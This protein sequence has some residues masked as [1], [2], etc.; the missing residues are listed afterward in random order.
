VLVT[1]FVG[2]AAGGAQPGLQCRL[3]PWR[4]QTPPG[5]QPGTEFTLLEDLRTGRSCVLPTSTLYGCRT[6]AL[7]ALAARTLVAPGVVTGA[8]LGTSA[9]AQLSL[10]LMARY[11][12]GLSH[13]AVCPTGDELDRPVAARVIDQL[14]LAGV[15][16]S[17]STAV[18]EAMFGA[19]LIVATITRTRW[20][21]TGQLPQGTVLINTSGEDPPSN[22]INAV[23]QVYVDDATL[24]ENHPHRYFA[25]KQMTGSNAG[26]TRPDRNDSR[27][28][29]YVEADFAEI[30][31]GAHPGRTHL[32]HILLV[33]LLSTGVLDVGLACELHRAALEHGFG[34][35]LDE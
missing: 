32:D 12:P 35:P 1:E 25:R 28:Y 34:I 21:D 7:A 5:D 3:T 33:E 26:S 18:T 17:L 6:A 29:R 4:G 20:P 30:L 19:T 14:D 8:V 31:T 10:M 15:G 2:K 9:A 13:V 24:I 16:W 22:L 11:L 27:R 23:D